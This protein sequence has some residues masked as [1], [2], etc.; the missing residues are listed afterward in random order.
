MAS[1]ALRIVHTA[2]HILHTV[3]KRVEKSP[4]R[5]RDRIASE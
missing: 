5:S 2:M 1:T 3:W 4:S